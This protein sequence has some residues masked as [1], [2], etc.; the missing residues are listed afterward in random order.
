MAE[1]GK[2]DKTLGKKP[3]LLYRWLKKRLTYKPDGSGK[4]N[5]IKKIIVRCP[6]KL[7]TKLHTVYV[8]HI[9]NN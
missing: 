9:L 6:V 1:N 4:N 5:V 2:A 3:K 8:H 7:F